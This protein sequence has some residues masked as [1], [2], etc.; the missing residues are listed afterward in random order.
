MNIIIYIAIRVMKIILRITRKISSY[1]KMMKDNRVRKPSTPDLRRRKSSGT[2]AKIHQERAQAIKRLPKQWGAGLEAEPRGLHNVGNY[3]YRNAAIQTLVNLP[4]LYYWLEKN[5]ERETE[6]GLRRRMR[7][8]FDQYWNYDTESAI[9]RECLAKFNETVN[10]LGWREPAPM[11]QDDSSDFL[12]WML[13]QV[14]NQGSPATF[15]HEVSKELLEFDGL[16]VAQTVEEWVCTGCGKTHKNWANYPEGLSIPV[17][18]YYKDTASSRTDLPY[19]YT[20]QPVTQYMAENFQQEKEDTCCTEENCPEKRV[21]KTVPCD[22]KFLAIPENLIFRLGCFGYTE[23]WRQVKYPTDTDLPEWIDVSHFMAWNVAKKDKKDYTYQLQSIVKH[24][25]PT[26]DSGHYSGLFTAPDG[27]KYVVNDEIV[28]LTT[29]QEYK[30]SMMRMDAPYVVTYLHLP[31][32]LDLLHRNDL[33]NALR[34]LALNYWSVEFK[35]EAKA[36]PAW[37]ARRVAAFERAVTATDLVAPAW[38]PGSNHEDSAEFLF[39]I[40]RRLTLYAVGPVQEQLQA[41]FIISAQLELVCNNCGNSTRQPLTQGTAP[42]GVVDDFND[43]TDWQNGTDIFTVGLQPDPKNAADDYDYPTHGSLEY[44]LARSLRE[45]HDRRC[46]HSACPVQGYEMPKL[47]ERKITAAPEYL[48]LK[49]TSYNTTANAQQKVHATVDIPKFLDIAGHCTW[50]PTKYMYQINSVVVH[51][52]ETVRSGHYTGFFEAAAG[53]RYVN[54]MVTTDRKF[55]E[56]K[57]LDAQRPL[58]LPY[59][60]TYKRVARS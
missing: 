32:F 23:D 57:T 15:G 7:I 60:V 3:C 26:V 30:D 20:T 27:Q 4:S 44:Y 55:E 11:V 31:A 59:I 50:N 39:W 36:P 45:Y 25:G 13:E 35:N 53:G 49:L 43:G 47:L 5:K 10:R 6:D 24:Q 14:R 12:A 22:T 33:W 29:L 2:V 18:P 41:L 8:F 38:Y 28:T 21:E 54:D 1:F 19:L 42:T 37:S 16:F 56:F 9:L 34:Q 58:D 51:H 17:I 46:Y 48:I 52:G 40:M